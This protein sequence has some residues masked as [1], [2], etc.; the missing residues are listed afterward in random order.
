MRTVYIAVIGVAVAA[1]VTGFLLFE[2]FSGAP[3]SENEKLPVTNQ[4]SGSNVQDNQD[5]DEDN[6]DGEDPS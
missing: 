3:E 4:N 5:K 2:T 6:G 1:I